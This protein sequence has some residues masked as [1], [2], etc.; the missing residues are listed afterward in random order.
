MAGTEVV[1]V[2]DHDFSKTITDGGLRIVS[3]RMPSVRSVAIGIW[4]TTGSIDDGNELAGIAH[5]LEH[6]VFKG[7]SNRSGLQIVQAIE[8]VG[9]HINAFTSKEITCFYAQVLDQHLD[10]ALDVLCD[11]LVSPTLSAEDLERE[12]LVISEEIRQY[13]DS[14]DELIFDYFSKILYGDHPLARPILGSV[15]TVGSISQNQLE[16]HLQ[17]NYPLNRI[18]IAAAGNLDHRRLVA[19]T[20]KRLRLKALD[21]PPEMPAV[22]YPQPTFERYYRPGQGAHLCR[23]LP[24][25]SYSDQRK[26]ASLLLSNLLGGGMSSRL[27]QRIREK[28]ALAYSVYTFLDSLKSS[29]VFGIYVGTDPNRVDDTL[30]VIDEEYRK[31]LKE[32][33]P[34]DELSRTKEQLKGNLVLGLEGTS[35]RMFR[36][37]KLE[38]YLG[39]FVTLDETLTLIDQVAEA[40]VM[41]LAQEFLVTEKQYTAIIYPEE[42]TPRRKKANKS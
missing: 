11:L 22:M 38:I 23:G 41:A 37:A 19:E 16:N 35:G 31:I 1:V 32:G 17:N 33:I 6:M 39:R 29:G 20:E 34:K 8:G 3:E 40:E 36:L 14:P 5:L 18:V 10:L 30:A 28:E 7:T 25:I 12:K 4:V 9:G 27:F 24:G 13:E 15:E 2:T 42:K 26:F 21:D